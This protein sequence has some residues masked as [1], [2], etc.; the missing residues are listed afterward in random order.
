[1][2]SVGLWV[3]VVGACL[4]WIQVLTLHAQ[5]GPVTHVLDLDGKD[6]YVELPP[7]IFNDL[8]AATVEGWVKWRRF[9]HWLRFFDCGKAQQAVVVTQGPG[10][11]EPDLQFDIHIGGGQ[12]TMIEIP[13]VLRTNEWIHIAAVS[14]KSGMKLY[15]NGL[16]AGEDSYTGSF[17]ATGSGDHVRLG[18][19][20]WTGNDFTDGQMAEVRVWKV[21]RTAA[22]IRENMFRHLSGQEPQLAGLWSFADGTARDL[23]PGGHDGKLMGQAKVVDGALP[24]P[25]KLPPLTSILGRAV[26]ERGEPVANATVRLEE[27]GTVTKTATDAAGLYHFALYHTNATWELSAKWGDLGYRDAKLQL[28]AGE[29]QRTDLLLKEAVSM[30]G[31]V[32]TLDTNTPLASVVVQVVMD[33]GAD[34]SSV[35]TGPRLKLADDRPVVD[36]TLTDTQGRFKFINLRPGTYLVRCH[37]LGGLKYYHEPVVIEENPKSQFANRPSVDFHLAP[38]KKGTWRTYRMRDGLPANQVLKINPD[39]ETGM[40]YLGTGQGLSRFDGKEFNNFTNDALRGEW[41]HVI[42]R[43]PKGI[44]WASKYNFGVTRYDPA[45]GSATLFTT[46]NGLAGNDVLAITSDATGAIWAG[47]SSSP[48]AVSR[49]DG[50]QFRTFTSADGLGGNDVLSILAEENGTVWVGTGGGVSR[51]D[52]KAFKGFTTADGLAGGAVTSICK[53]KDGSLWFG[54]PRGVSHFDGETFTDFAEDDGLFLGLE[55]AWRTIVHEDASGVMWFGASQEQDGSSGAGVWRYDGRSFVHFTMADGLPA[56][57]VRDIQSTPD[58]TLWFGCWGGLA[59]YDPKTMNSFTEAD[60]L[61]DESISRLHAAPDGTLWLGG[62]SRGGLTR[63]DGQT[64]QKLDGSENLLVHGFGK[65]MRTDPTGVLWVGTDGQGLFRYDGRRFTPVR[66]QSGAGPQEVTDIEFNPDGTMWIVSWEGLWRYDRTNFFNL[67]TNIGLKNLNLWTGHLDARGVLWFGGRLGGLARYD[68]QHLRYFADEGV[69]TGSSVFAI[70]ED[71]DHTL[72]IANWTRGVFRYDGKQ[73]ENFTKAKGQLAEDGVVDILRDARGTHWFATGTDGGGISRFDDAI[74]SSL[75]ERDG[76]VDP[77]TFSL[78][79]APPGTLWIGTPHG[80]TRYQLSHDRPRA[81]RVKVRTDQGEFA[82]F[83]A[84]P[85]VMTRQRVLFKLSVTDFKSRPD[86]RI[87]RYRVTAGKPPEAAGTAQIDYRKQSG[88]SPAITA[89]QLEWTTNTPGQYVFEFQFIDRDLNYSK[90]TVG[91]LTFVLPWYRNA[92]ILGPAALA[93][94]GL[95]AWAVIARSLYLRKRREAERLR[96]QMLEQEQ[97]ARHQLE[98][99]NQELAA[100]RDVAER[101]RQS[102]DEANKAKSQFLASMS[103]E[104]RTPLNAIIGY[105]EMLQEEAPE[106]GASEMV[107]DLEKIHSAARHQLTLINDILDLSKI[108]AG[109]MTLFIEEFDLARLV[110]EVEAT[111]RP[112]VTKKGNVLEVV[113]PAEIGSMRSDQTKLRQVLFNLLSN[114]AK[115]TENG[116]IRLEVRSQRSEVGGQQLPTSDLRPP[117]AVIFEVSDTG[118]GMTAEQLGKL[119]QSFTQADT[120]TTRKYG[121]TGLGLALSRKF[122]QLMGGDLTVRSEI[123]KG[124]VFTASLPFELKEGEPGGD[125]LKR[126]PETEGL[127]SKDNGTIVLVIDD[128]ANARD[129]MRRALIREGYHVELAATGPQGLELA[130]RLKPT[131]ITLDV[132]MPGMDGW[133]VLTTLKS[134]PDLADIPV[135]MMTILDDKNLAFSLGASD[136]LTK[137]VDWAQLHR[138]LA[139]HEL[140]ARNSSVLIVDDDPQARDLLRRGLEKA[141]CRV[142]EADQGRAALA[143]VSVEVPALIL[144]DLMMPEM[145]G[146]EFLRRL[147]ERPDGRQ[148]PVIV[149]TSKDLTEEDHRRLNGSVAQILQKGGYS[150]DELLAQIRFL[151]QQSHHGPHT[152][153][154]S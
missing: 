94:F 13:R 5:P 115:F 2:K 27:G 22:Q 128:D 28:K 147:R 152:S 109:K 53:S 37:V 34:R 76:L 6:S 105:S 144:L 101:A 49:Y 75:D 63:Y 151:I 62:N 126:E 70:T 131:V 48:A 56:N 4:T 91:M 16:L 39:P 83:T 140:S 88:W 123:G 65:L 54:A 66:S 82:E 67:G 52:G 100:A 19:D 60:G 110:R 102:A 139:K 132:M 118:I 120:S 119:F 107:P 51:Y 72:W 33:T 148:I 145:D 44:W 121:G 92:K 59:Q 146:F 95:I 61:A 78:A 143:A 25:G 57:A 129:L 108:E 1:M 31:R 96:E 74:W 24:E 15:V 36:T 77:A 23:S 9:G 99:K 80:L 141:G 18:R 58:G 69:V 3:A 122:C 7:N 137:P 93:N 138:L 125:L 11:G 150:F 124:S 133:A 98:A 97:Q 90:P 135:I 32:A 20:V 30:S 134:T 8:E 117:T 106:I 46:N 142:R 68:G 149:I 114:A 85:S 35:G 26:N 81:P 86:Y 45:T 43:T 12:H 64:F 50:K 136:Y 73:F 42:D 130:A 29:S 113:C 41:V 55:G 104:L 21:A 153:S 127:D 10:G 71:P 111:V 40:L 47:G 84:V 14:G 17:H 79:E 103:H 89:A 112:L 154:R 116:T 87:Y 38:F